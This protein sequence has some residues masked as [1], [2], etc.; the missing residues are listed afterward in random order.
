M[1]SSFYVAAMMVHNAMMGF[2]VKVVSADGRATVAR[3][4]TADHGAAAHEKAW[5]LRDAL[6]H[7]LVDATSAAE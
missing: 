7:A 5:Q 1:N 3:F 6:A 4:A 2:E